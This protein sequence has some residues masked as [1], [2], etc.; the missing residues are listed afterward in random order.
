MEQ[1][2]EILSG[3]TLEQKAALCAG[4]DAWNT[5]SF[6]SPKVP[7]VLMTDGPHGLRKQYDEKTAML[8]RSVP[9]TCFPTAAT[10]ACSWDPQ[11][12]HEVGAA[13]GA[14]ARSQGVSMVLGP[15]INI[16]R[17]PLCGRNFEYFSEDPVLSGELGAAIIDGMQESGTA[18][19]L[20]HFAANNREHFRMVSNSIVG[21]RALREIYLAGFERAVKKGK[22]S[23]VMSAYNML[24]GEYCGESPA[25]I[26]GILR[27][28]WGFDGLVVSDWGACYHREQ[29]IR[30]GMDLEMP[31]SGHE[32]ADRILRSIEKGRLSEDALDDCVRRVLAFALS[33]EKNKEQPF[34]CDMEKNHEIARKAALQSAV[35]LK[36]ENNILPLKPGIKVALL[37]EFA[38]QPRY[39]GAGSSMI[40]PAHLETA[41][42]E[43]PKYGISMEYSKGYSVQRDDPEEALLHEAEQTAMRADV[44]VILAGLP[45]RCETEGVDRT[46]LAMPPNQVALIKRIARIRPVVVVLHCG[47]PV[48]MPWLPSASGLL[49]CYLSGEAGAS[50]AAMLLTGK[51]CPGGKLAE[52]YP[53]ALSDTPSYHFFSDDQ[54]NI[55]YRESTYVGYRYYDACGKKVLF[56]FGYGLSYTTFSYSPLRISGEPA[57]GSLT[58]ELEVKNTGAV[59]GAEIVQ[60]YVRLTGCP[61][62]QLRAFQKV[63]LAPGE[64]KTVVF[65]LCPRDFSFYENGWQLASGAELIVGSHSRDNRGEYSFDISGGKDVPAYPVASDGHWDAVQFYKLFDKI[66]QVSFSTR[67]F[68]INAT[69]TDFESTSIGRMIR[70]FI[71]KFVHHHVHPDNALSAQILLQLLNENPIRALVS[72]SGGLLT[73]GMARGIL[74]I[75]NGQIFLG[76]VAVVVENHKRRKKEKK[77]KEDVYSE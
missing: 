60:L 76:I 66:P 13:L 49:H 57:N 18:A 3:L 71:Y 51:E 63:D 44:A 29:G 48:E 62:R 2:E 31:Y 52:S 23:A 68:T 41:I 22:P 9:A 33:C 77:S 70:K 38:E 1:I 24:N 58:A 17:S 73:Y 11:L 15:G 20:K 7:G 27:G 50:A 19:C 21:S 12:L 45:A 72:M 16:K 64:V 4:K 10:T 43:F 8:E 67:P 61:Y 14:E 75:V 5:V 6:S 34:F 47:A 46:H 37:G 56:P 42:E 32:N 69:L 53:L 40:A 25:L 35:L 74:M 28:E 55:E 59:R 65:T 54:H 39:Q 26:S 36:N 30:A